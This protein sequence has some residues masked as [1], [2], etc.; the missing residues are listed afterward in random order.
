MAM[1]AIEGVAS[2]Q[3]NYEKYKDMFDNSDR[4]LITMDSFYQL[5]VAEMQN[6]DPLE[7]TSNTEFISQMASFTA[8]QSQQNAFDIQ[9]QQYANSL[10]G[11]TVTVKSG[12][13]TT[14]TGVVT[15]VTTGDNPQIT[16]NGKTYALSSMTQVHTGDQQTGSIGDQGAFAASLLG[17]SV[18]VKSLDETGATYLDEGTVQSLE[19]ED[20]EVRL[21]VNGYAYSV[22]DVVRVT[23]AQTAVTQTEFSAQDIAQEIASAVSEAIGSATAV[24]TA[25]E[26]NTAASAASQGAAV[27][28]TELPDE[29]DVQDIE[30]I[31]EIEAANNQQLRE[32]F[33]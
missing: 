3:S 14:V 13:D 25:A 26:N 28:P 30:D 24:R 21:V 2:P 8:L 20:G 16:V 23:E 9:A 11:K 17:K 33:E 6:Q 15:A 7:P 22:S 5:L 31:I 1:D 10:V 4:D 12:Q 18:L 29:P 32:L 19:I 27:Q